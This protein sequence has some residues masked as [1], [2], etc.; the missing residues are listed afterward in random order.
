VNE[1]R[2]H[3]R[4]VTLGLVHFLVNICIYVFI[5]APVC[6]CSGMNAAVRAAVRMGLY[7]GAKVYFIHEGY[8]GM[9]DG[10]NNI[11]EATWESVSSMLQVGGTVIGSARCKEFR[12]HEGRLRA[13]LNLVQREITNICV[14]G[15][16]GS[17]TGANLFRE[18]W[19]GLL[20][21]LKQQGQIDDEAVRNNSILHIVGMVGSID[22]DFC[23]TDMTIGTDSALHRIIEV[24]DAIM[25]T[26]QSHQRTFVLE[27]MGRHCGYL[28]LVSALACGA[29]WVFIPEMPP[30]DGWEDSMC[31]KL[32]E[33]RA[34]KKRLNIM[35]VAEGAIDRHNKA[36]TAD[37]I[38]ELVVSRLGFDTRVTILGH[39]QRGGTPS[40]FDRILASRMGVEAVLA[41][42]EASAD[43]P[44]CVV[45]LVGNQAV[46]LPL[47]E[48]VQMTQE[49]QKAMDE[50]KFEEA[51][52]LRGRYGVFSSNFNVAVLNVGAPAGMNAAGH[53]MFAVS[54]GFE[55][56][57]KGKV[58][59][60]QRKGT[61][62]TKDRY[63]LY[64]GQVQTLQRTGTD[65]TKDRYRL[66]KGKV[67]TLQRKGTDST[68]DR[69]RLYK[70]K[71]YMGLLELAKA[72]DAHEALCVPMIMVPATVSNNIPGSDLS[73]GSDTA[74]NAITHT[75]DRI[76]QSAS[77]TKR[78]VFII[79]TMGGYCGYLATVGGL[80]A[81]ADSVYIYEEPFDIRDL[82]ANVE[83]LTEKMKTSIQRGIVLRNENCNENFS[84]D[85]MYQLYSE[86]GRGVF[87]CRKNILG[88]MQ[89]GGAPSPF[90]RNFSTKIAAKAMQWI[91]RS[92][93]E[94]F[95]GGRV[96][97]NSE[98]T[99]CLLGMRRRALVFQPV[100]HLQE[101][102]DFVH[103]IPKEQW[104]LKLRPL[105]KILAKYKTSYDVSDSGQLEH[106]SRVRPK[107]SHTSA[108][109]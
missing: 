100:S 84:T 59:T 56:L 64:K 45:S 14:I 3:S 78:R 98:D 1:P 12:T 22:N 34:D 74:L 61:D 17:L 15:G 43:T 51:V 71:A 68:K 39:V 21:E 75:C 41:L 80:A 42:L 97:A 66:Y 60:L 36:I 26:A 16:D 49:V 63:R 19:S 88:H 6:L 81:G 48:C 104:W 33:N 8:Q 4:H 106:V 95:K 20:Q 5:Y 2:Q 108:A 101:E 38:K 86:E 32:S 13:A 76:K 90:D 72:R 55:G 91:T 52:R 30:E 96:F 107:E 18:E 65:S 25:T 92:L 23:G 102:T 99:A 83:H 37:N 10:G 11:I 28:A 53:R 77:G 29:D 67:Q 82:Q 27:V 93:K 54:D 89:Q 47:M 50:K 40:A 85:F 44:A 9:V 58:Q 35:I 73:I 57:Y 79:E 105:M 69:Y 70:G 94:S 46:R 62:S 87:D 109:I 103:R 7:V 31:Q 24:V